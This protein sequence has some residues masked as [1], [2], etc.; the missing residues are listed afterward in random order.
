V[1]SLFVGAV[2]GHVINVYDETLN[3]GFLE[4]PSGGGQVPWQESLAKR[5]ASSRNAK[6]ERRKKRRKLAA[7]QPE[8]EPLSK[9]EQARLENEWL[10]I[11]DDD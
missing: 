11:E 3:G 5:R 6:N 1:L 10:G 9:S 8:P 4:T 7:R 2:V